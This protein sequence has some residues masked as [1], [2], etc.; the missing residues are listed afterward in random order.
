MGFVLGVW[1]AFVCFCGG[2]LRCLQ[3]FSSWGWFCCF[4]FLVCG[5]WGWEGVCFLLNI[6]YNLLVFV[7]YCGS[8]EV[9]DG[10]VDK[11]QTSPNEYLSMY[12]TILQYKIS[13]STCLVVHDVINVML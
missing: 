5:F 6:C 7:A 3:F 10:K 13:C 8:W 9:I 11:N 1:L 12:D 4:V 2:L